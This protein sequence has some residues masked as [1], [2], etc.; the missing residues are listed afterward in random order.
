MNGA[1]P[2]KPHQLRN[3]ARV[4][5]V[6]LDRHRLEGVAHVPSLQQFHRQAFFLQRRK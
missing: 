5:A 4:V 6:A 3:S 2:A 1:E